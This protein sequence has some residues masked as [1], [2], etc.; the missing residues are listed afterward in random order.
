[1]AYQDRIAKCQ[2]YHTGSEEASLKGCGLQCWIFWQG[3]SFDKC[4]SYLVRPL[5]T[6]SGC[7]Y[8]AGIIKGDASESG[9]RGLLFRPLRWRQVEASVT[10]NADPFHPIPNVSVQRRAKAARPILLTAFRP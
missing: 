10:L 2:T 5:Y 1:M 7:N 9:L 3:K 4:D 6:H 8:C